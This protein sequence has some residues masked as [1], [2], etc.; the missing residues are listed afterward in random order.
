MLVFAL[1]CVSA[2]ANAAD[3]PSATSFVR[4]SGTNFTVDDRQFFVVGVNNHYLTYSSRNEVTRVLDDAVTMG[5]NVVRIFLQP[6]IGSLDGSTAT[7]WNWKSV[8]DASDLAVK[9][10]YLLY[11]DP[12]TGGMAINDGPNGMQKVD[13]VIAEAGRRHLRLVIGFLDFWSYTGGV[14]QMRAWYGSQD[15]S[16]FFFRDPR[17]KRDYRSWVSH[18]V[19]RVNPLTGLAYRDDPTIMA[20]ELMNEGNAEPETL[21]LTWTAEMSAYV[22]S[23]DPNHLVSSGHANVEAKLSDL[24]IPTLDFGTWHGYPLFYKLTVS[25]F[26][27]K[28]TEFCQLAA[29]ANK[30]V[31]L[32]EF[33]YARSNPDS[34]QAYALWLDTLARDS[35]C[36]GWMVWRLVS[37]QD[38][39]R[40][41]IDEYDQFDVRNDGGAIWN[42][43]KAAAS[44]AAQVRKT[45]ARTP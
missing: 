22:K 14:Q 1:L 24:T 26:N 16:G 19:Q 21:R 18:V 11:W 42:V 23:L 17:T 34:A 3:N 10:S 12:R 27:D 7:V 5:A 20:W 13:F 4:I 29:R 28:I 25:Q 43:F 33:G 15:K 45:A 41:P 8:G 30:P 40:Y 6:V 36:A 39:G 2:A 9:G 35:N 31:L 32:E 37:R 38:S 44:R